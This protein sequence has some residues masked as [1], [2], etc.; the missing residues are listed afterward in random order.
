MCH[1]SWKLSHD[2]DLLAS[3]YYV[4]VLTHVLTHAIL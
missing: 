3:D 4:V 1:V 2:F